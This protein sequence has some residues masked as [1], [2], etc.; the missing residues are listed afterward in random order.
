[1][2][3]TSDG[4]PPDRADR[5]DRLDGSNRLDRPHRLDSSDD[6]LPRPGPTRRTVTAAALCLVGAAVAVGCATRPLWTLAAAVVVVLLAATVRVP[7]ALPVLVTPALLLVNRV[8]DT[9]SVSD[10]V[11]FAAFWPALLL[12]PR[13]M[14][15]PV[16]TVLWATAF[17]QATVLFTVIVNPYPANAVEWVHSWLLAGG[18]VLVGWAIG[19]AGRARTAFGLLLV[20]AGVVAVAA[21]A[22]FTVDLAHG[23]T[24]AVYLDEPF[25]MHKNY[26]GCVLAVAAVLVYARPRWLGWSDRLCLAAFVLFTAGVL[27]SQSRQALVSLA[28]AVAVIALRP[29]PDRHRSRLVL[30]LVA[31]SAMVVAVLVQDQLASGDEYNSAYQRLTWFTQSLTIWQQYPLFG[32]GLRWWY[33]DRFAERFQPPNAELEMLSSAGVVG[34]LGFLV[35]F[36]A[37]LVVL[38]RLDRRFGTLAFSVVLMRLVQGQLDLFW[39]AAQVSVPFWVAGVCL[40]A[41]DRARRDATPDAHANAHAL[42]DADADGRPDVGSRSATATAPR[43]EHTPAPLALRDT[44]TPSPAPVSP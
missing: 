21:L 34:L 23:Y 25:G 8:G 24:G 22:Q 27:V 38:W 18:A 11:L 28:V 40:G 30:V 12:H 10:L 14:G 33:T 7:M 5:P 37:V 42:A 35:M 1:M 44:D 6:R 2:T 20:G 3:S 31:V 29:D 9:L 4:R 41:A 13:P 15:R 39:V 17:Y 19:A 16:R 32:A 26:I 43:P 36:A